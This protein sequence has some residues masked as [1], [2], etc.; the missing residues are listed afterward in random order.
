MA[1]S[2]AIDEIVVL[3]PDGHLD[4]AS[5]AASIGP[6]ALPS[7]RF[8]VGGS[9]RQ[10]SVQCGLAAAAADA[11]VIVCHDAARPFAS[12]E[13]FAAV[14]HVLRAARS[15]GTAGVIPV[16]PSADTVKRI[17]DGRVVETVPR[18]E[19]ALVQTPQAFDAGA[20]R[21]AHARARDGGLEGTDDAAL[22]EAA[23]YAV[24]V[25][26]GEPENFKIT[27]ADDLER[28]ERRLAGEPA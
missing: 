15:S 12:A 18:D 16:V 23:G 7:L 28:A 21:D 5:A 19:V 20:L 6:D 8:A 10:A 25:V 9:T 14:V 13:L 2:G 22:L 24:A 27:T 1:G 11:D 3:V 4:E 17:A 26:P